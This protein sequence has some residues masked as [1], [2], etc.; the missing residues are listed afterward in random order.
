M[1]FGNFQKPVGRLVLK[2]PKKWLPNGGL[3][4]S[5]PT[6]R[7]LAFRKF[8][9][10]GSFLRLA[11]L[12]SLGSLVS[13]QQL[14]QDFLDQLPPEAREMAQSQMDSYGQAFEEEEHQPQFSSEEFRTRPL[15]LEE[16]AKDIVVDIEILRWG[17]VENQQSFTISLQ[18][19]PEF[20]DNIRLDK[21]QISLSPE[22]WAEELQL[23]FDVKEAAS[24]S[25]GGSES[26]DI[27]FLVTSED[28]TLTPPERKFII[29]LRY[30]SGGDRS[31]FV[32]TVRED[33]AGT[34]GLYET[35]LECHTEEVTLFTVDPI[36][37]F[38]K[39]FPEDQHFFY[40]LVGPDGEEIETKPYAPGEDFGSGVL[41]SMEG[42]ISPMFKVFDEFEYDSDGQSS[43]PWQAGTYTVKAA[44]Q[45]GDSNNPY[46]MFMNTL[47]FRE[48]GTFELVDPV[49]RYKGAMVVDEKRKPGHGRMSASAGGSSASY[50][51]TWTKTGMDN[52]KK[53]LGVSGSLNFDYPRELAW[54]RDKLSYQGHVSVSG[55]S[56]GHEG[57]RKDSQIR[58]GYAQGFLIADGL[59]TL[60]K[61]RPNG[62]LDQVR[63]SGGVD[64][65]RRPAGVNYGRFAL[66]FTMPTF[67]YPHGNPKRLL[68]W[69]LRNESHLFAVIHSV[70]VTPS[71]IGGLNSGVFMAI[72]GSDPE[73]IAA[74]SI[75]EEGAAQEEVAEQDS[76]EDEAAESIAETD[77]SQASDDPFGDSGFGSGDSSGGTSGSG[78]SGRPSGSGTSGG[79]FDP[80]RGGGMTATDPVG[81]GAAIE[82]PESARGPQFPEPSFSSPEDSQLAD[83]LAS[84][85]PD[86]IPPS[87]PQVAG[88]ISQWIG[89]AE[90]PA[91]ID[92]D[93]DLRYNE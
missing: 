59:A 5:L 34:V 43:I 45:S 54:S 87:H 28:K 4:T 71:V 58:L 51:A 69:H 20:V 56:T 77:T 14:P 52:V 32:T 83:A 89:E 84:N 78:S 79:I 60:T 16:T 73:G 80:F 90:P 11:L 50:E 17:E 62:G 57:E 18:S 81:E 85:D 70:N 23:T 67:T 39:G 19:Q 49:L 37:I 48:I 25:E 36:W 33:F 40:T 10:V 9:W 47:E 41:A 55:S 75:R 21:T 86:R 24:G 44:Y 74:T 29:P 88:F 38:F 61:L 46:A 64:L 30:Q 7:L 93:V 66:D 35:H 6:I 65:E 53:D 91:N 76:S 15:V 42:A 1:V 68:G 12:G 82:L 22:E 72:Y 26:G 27:V 13:A 2:P 3:R 8:L 63:G 31:I 92:P